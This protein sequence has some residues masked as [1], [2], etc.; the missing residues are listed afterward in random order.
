MICYATLRNWYALICTYLQW[1]S[2]VESRT[3][4]KDKV[5]IEL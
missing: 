5:K 4:C 1:K 2:G 3:G